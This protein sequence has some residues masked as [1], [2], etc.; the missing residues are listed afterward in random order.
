MKPEEAA[1]VLHDAG[2]PRLRKVARKTFAA[3]VANLL[4]LFEM[5]GSVYGCVVVDRKF[6][7]MYVLSSGRIAVE[8]SDAGDLVDLELPV[9]SRSGLPYSRVAEMDIHAALASRFTSDELLPQQQERTNWHDK[10]GDQFLGP[11]VS[12]PEDETPRDQ[13]DRRRTVANLAN[14]QTYVDFMAAGVVRLGAVNADVPITKKLPTPVQDAF[15]AEVLACLIQ[16]GLPVELAVSIRDESR[17][18]D[19][20][21]DYLHFTAEEQQNR[22]E[23]KG[24]W[25]RIVDHWKAGHDPRW[26]YFPEPSASDSGDSAEGEASSDS[27]DS[28]SGS[29]ADT[30]SSGDDIDEEDDAASVE[31][32]GSGSE[33]DDESEAGSEGSD[34]SHSSGALSAYSERTQHWLLET[35]SDVGSTQAHEQDW[36]TFDPGD[37]DDIGEEDVGYSSWSAENDF[38]ES[39][40]SLE[41]D[42]CFVLS[43]A[44]RVLQGLCRIVPVTKEEMDEL[45]QTQYKLDL[46]R[47]E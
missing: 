16:K 19:N 28:D 25:R 36:R 32:D 8:F 38:Y 6:A 30:G 1:Q 40:S 22:P 45:V 33:A 31:A 10:L 20:L 2:L 18:A 27:S 46:E 47:Y 42:R 7:R 35:G 43:I 17:R 4:N 24:L 23:S 11:D 37:N 9:Q 41:S 3:A 12:D 39:I 26:D 5:C 15:D 14:V 44:E 13:F 34:S 21:A 29:E